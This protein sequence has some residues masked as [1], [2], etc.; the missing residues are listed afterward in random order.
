LYDE[1]IPFNH[2]LKMEFWQSIT[3]NSKVK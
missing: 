3:E 1:I 2:T